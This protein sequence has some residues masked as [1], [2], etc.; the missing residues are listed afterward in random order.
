MRVLLINEY[1]DFNNFGAFTDKLLVIFS[2][3]GGIGTPY[4]LPPKEYF[5]NAA[6]LFLF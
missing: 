5:I 2:D 1:I 6:M 3:Y 4:P